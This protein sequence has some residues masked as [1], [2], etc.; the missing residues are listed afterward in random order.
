LQEPQYQS[1]S[2][3]CA[4]PKIRIQQV[5]SDRLLDEIAKDHVIRM[6]GNQKWQLPPELGGVVQAPNRPTEELTLWKACELFMKYP[7]IKAKTDRARQDYERAMLRLVRIFGK[8]VPLKS[9]WIPDVRRYQVSRANEGASE[10]TINNDLS[11]L[12]RIFSVMIELL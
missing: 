7:E 6:Y 4:V 2:I 8:D 5:K 12:S 3:K 11:C 1:L 9:L 10:S